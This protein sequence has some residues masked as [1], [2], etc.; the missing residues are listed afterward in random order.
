M[1]EAVASGAA[2]DRIGEA[3]GPGDASTAG[4]TQAPAPRMLKFMLDGRETELPE[5]E[6]VGNF[7]KG[8]ESAKLLSL[9]QQR[10]EEALREKATAEGLFARLKKGGAETR[11][12]LRELGVDPAKVGEEEILEMIAREK[13][14]PEQK[15]EKELHDKLKGFEDEKKKAEDDKKAAV[16]KEE[17]QRHADELGGLFT[18]ALIASGL[19]KSAAPVL[20]PRL[21]AIYLQNEKAG[22]ESTPEEMAHHA[23]EGF[24]EVQTGVLGK[25]QGAE[26]LDYLGPDVVRAV[27]TAN[28]QRS[29]G[30]R[31]PGVPISTGAPAKP[32]PGA[33]RKPTES[34]EDFLRRLSE[35]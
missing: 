29:G 24:R 20:F 35:G 4:A 23:M 15:R 28:L 10:K 25:L 19:P 2:T 13:L 17:V 18:E 3:R 8:R 7:K 14:T 30:Q 21:A 1:S 33:Q 32:R 26:L 22:L 11:A 34:G 27:L 9:A 6:V 12:V 31:V 5:S 16:H